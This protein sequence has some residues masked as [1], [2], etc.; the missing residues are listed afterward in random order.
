[1]LGAS[2]DEQSTIQK[3]ITETAVR[4]RL[5]SRYTA[6]VAVDEACVVGDGQ[7]LCMVQPVELPRSV[8]RKGATGEAPAGRALRVEAWGVT[9]R[10]RP[11]ARLIV[12]AVD[13]ESAASRARVQP[14][15]ELF[16][17]GR[18]ALFGA[19]HLESL[20]W[21]ATGRPR[22]AGVSCWRPEGRSPARAVQLPRPRKPGKP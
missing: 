14:G 20:L 13:P 3:Q 17:L 11:D 19:R 9:L 6:F 10:E 1:M 12:A 21:Q 16:A 22:G 8:S 5:A 7:P 2:K 4:Y 18:Y 15:D